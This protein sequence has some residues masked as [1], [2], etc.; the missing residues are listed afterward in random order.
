LSPNC[1][2]DSRGCPLSGRSLS[3]QKPVS[4]WDTYDT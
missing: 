4:W 2:P 3:D 1:H